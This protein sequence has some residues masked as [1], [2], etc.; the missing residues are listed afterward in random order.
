MAYPYLKLHILFNSNGLAIWSGLPDIM[1]IKTRVSM[2]QK[3]VLN[4]A[5]VD[6]KLKF[7]TSVRRFYAQERA[8]LNKPNKI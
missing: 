6:Y 3:L 7:L 4:L 5:H 1:H 2:T 8:L